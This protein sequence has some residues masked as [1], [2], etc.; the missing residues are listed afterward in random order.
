[1]TVKQLG[2]LRHRYNG[3]DDAHQV[4][5]DIVI[6]VDLH[7]SAVDH[8]DI[9]VEALIDAVIAQ[10]EVDI[11]TLERLG[12]MKET[13]RLIVCSVLGIRLTYKI[14]I[15]NLRREVNTHSQRLKS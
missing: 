5:R 12:E 10:A 14:L 4:N 15:L 7:D 3:D 6:T 9:E 2:A 11:V 1:M 13:R 8:R